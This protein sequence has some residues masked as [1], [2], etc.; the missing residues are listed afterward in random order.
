M[1][2]WAGASVLVATLIEGPGPRFGETTETARNKPIQKVLVL[3]GFCSFAVFHRVPKYSPHDR[4][5]HWHRSSGDTTASRPT[6]GDDR[7]QRPSYRDRM[8]RKMALICKGVQRD[9]LRQIGTTGKNQWAGAMAKPGRPARGRY[10]APGDAKSSRAI[11][12]I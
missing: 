8:R 9:C 2:R 7:P 1:G 10:F 5:P 11:S 4:R 6:F 3:K 12:S